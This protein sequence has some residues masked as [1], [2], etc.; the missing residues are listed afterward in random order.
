MHCESMGHIERFNAGVFKQVFDRV[1][2]TLELSSL[3]VRNI[4]L[5]PTFLWK[6]S[7]GFGHLLHKQALWIN[8]TQ[9]KVH[10]TDIK[11][12]LG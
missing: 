5:Y 8:V 6:N 1:G 12:S 9:W 7:F 2:H 10:Y 3:V 4:F 11:T